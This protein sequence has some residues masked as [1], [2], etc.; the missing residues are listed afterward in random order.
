[1]NMIMILLI[2]ITLT[3]RGQLSQLGGRV[4]ALVGG[5]PAGLLGPVA[6][7]PQQVGT[8]N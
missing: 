4:A 6:K 8:S 2:Y 5:G 3:L 7:V 1:M